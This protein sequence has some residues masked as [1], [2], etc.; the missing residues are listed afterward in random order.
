M[1]DWYYKFDTHRYVFDI[2]IDT[3]DTSIYQTKIGFYSLAGNGKDAKE[4]VQHGK[5]CLRPPFAVGNFTYEGM[6]C[7]IWN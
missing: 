1:F 4:A 2:I 3:I 5:G 6:D 7:Q